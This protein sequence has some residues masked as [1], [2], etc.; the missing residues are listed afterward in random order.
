MS[1]KIDSKL[2][3][4]SYH[5]KTVEQAFWV[6]NNYEHRQDLKNNQSVQDWISASRW[7]VEHLHI[8]Y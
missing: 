4:L 8:E 1:E 7:V 6:L 5:G 2:K 3:G